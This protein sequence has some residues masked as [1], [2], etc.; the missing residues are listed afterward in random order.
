MNQR[1]YCNKL[2]D[3]FAKQSRVCCSLLS[4]IVAIRDATVRRVL[5]VTT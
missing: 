2:I 5:Y 1:W 3:E 4:N